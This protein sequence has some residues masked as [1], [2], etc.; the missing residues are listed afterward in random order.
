MKPPVATLLIIMISMDLFCAEKK[1][2]PLEPIKFYEVSKLEGNISK[3]QNDSKTIQNL[4]I[5]KN[6]L[7]HVNKEGEF[8]EN[9]KNWYSL[10]SMDNN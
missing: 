6:L 5:I 3:H 7:D 10:E 8:T 1:W 4:K 9:K 2:V